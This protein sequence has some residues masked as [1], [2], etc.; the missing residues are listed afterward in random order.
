MK[1]L[2]LTFLSFLFIA[3]SD[4]DSSS[5]FIVSGTGDET[6]TIT[7]NASRSSATHP[8]SF[9]GNAHFSD[10]VGTTHNVNSVFWQ[11]GD[12]AS[13]G[14]EQMAETGETNLLIGE[15]N[16]DKTAGNSDNLILGDGIDKHRA[17]ERLLYR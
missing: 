2:I 10:L 4:S 3:C 9:P 17:A 13:N 1:P 5:D 7:L 11:A 15:I 14:I 6:Y 16:A 8:Q 12:I